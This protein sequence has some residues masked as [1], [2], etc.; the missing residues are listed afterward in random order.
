MTAPAPIPSGSRPLLQRREATAT[1]RRRTLQRAGKWP[2]PADAPA[3]DL[4]R[5]RERALT[6]ARPVCAPGGGDETLRTAI[7]PRFRV[8]AADRGRARQPGPPRTR[9][10]P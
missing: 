3:R 5:A 4:E 6:W 2:G 1:T 7:P 10:T 9:T 8:A